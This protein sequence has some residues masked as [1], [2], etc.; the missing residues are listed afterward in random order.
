[1]TLFQEVRPAAEGLARKEDGEHIWIGQ[2]CVIAK[3]L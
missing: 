1:M 2:A 3:E